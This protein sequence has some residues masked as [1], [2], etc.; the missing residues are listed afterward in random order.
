MVDEAAV[1][2][3]IEHVN[4]AIRSM[5][6]ASQLV[7]LAGSTFSADN[8]VNSLLLQ[9]QAE[10][11][12]YVDDAYPQTARLMR[13]TTRAVRFYLAEDG[14]N[15]F[16]ENRESILAQYD[17][18][19]LLA[20]AI[21]G[22]HQGARRRLE[23]LNGQVMPVSNARK[24]DADK[25][26]GRPTSCSYKNKSIERKSRNSTRRV[27]RPNPVHKIMDNKHMRRTKTTGEPRS[28]KA[29]Q[30]TT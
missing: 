1:N 22:T 21:V 27:G 18:T 13:N 8:E 2:A 6:A 5:T 29:R 24:E 10:T 7:A 20:A 14:Y 15:F 3:L 11:L 19:D 23:G 30:T 25:Q 17:A 12:T 9:L 26:I 16:L 28:K 4:T